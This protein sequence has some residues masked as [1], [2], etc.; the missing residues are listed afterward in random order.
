[1]EV[2]AEAAVELAAEV[3][4]RFAVAVESA[5]ARMAVA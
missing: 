2:A 3:G 4:L 1:M 5:V